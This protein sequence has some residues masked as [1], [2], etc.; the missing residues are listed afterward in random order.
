MINRMKIPNK[1]ITITL[2]I[3]VLHKVRLSYE[4]STNKRIRFYL[5]MLFDLMTIFYNSRRMYNN[6]EIITSKKE[7][8][9]IILGLNQTAVSKK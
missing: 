7:N 9:K 4:N 3:L 8:F 1:L 5:L 2:K 6:L